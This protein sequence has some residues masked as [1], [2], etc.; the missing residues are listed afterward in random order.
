[1]KSSLERLRGKRA[2]ITGATGGIGQAIVAAF[3][4]AGIS[5]MASGQN[6]RKLSELSAQ[7]PGIIIER[8]D[9]KSGEEALHLANAALK[10]FGGL[11][12]LINNAGF[13]IMRNATDLE[14]IDFDAMFDVNIRAPFIL[15]KII[16]KAMATAGSGYIINIGS[17]ASYTP[18]A[19]MAAYCATKYALLGFSESLALELRDFGVKVT[20][21]MP[22]STATEFG[23]SDSHKRLKE[24]PGILLPEDIADTVMYILGQSGRAWSSQVN[25]RPLNPNK[26]PIN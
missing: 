5:V 2:L 1:L 7:F 6:P 23:G 4:E 10:H 17:G 22:G 14:I 25:L 8:A 18:I 19:G 21:I 24:K 26:P 11:D 16:G 3:V 13:G 12:I 20:I 15:A 9:F